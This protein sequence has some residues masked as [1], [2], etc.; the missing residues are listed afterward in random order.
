MIPSGVLIENIG[1]KIDQITDLNL[2]CLRSEPLI[3]FFDFLHDNPASSD[4]QLIYIQEVPLKADLGSFQM[5]SIIQK[6]GAARCPFLFSLSLS[7]AYRKG[8]QYEMVAQRRPSVNQC[9][10]LTCDRS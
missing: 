9:R 7:K 1:F 6:V 8:S 3:A 10:K 4:C 2:G 5:M